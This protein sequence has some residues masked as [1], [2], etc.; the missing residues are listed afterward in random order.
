MESLRLPQGVKKV[1]VRKDRRN[2]REGRKLRNSSCRRTT[3]TPGTGR[4]GRT[5]GSGHGQVTF[6]GDG[7]R[8]IPGTSPSVSPLFSFST[9]RL[10]G[11]GHWGYSYTLGG[12]SPPR[13][14]VINPPISFPPKSHPIEDGGKKTP[15]QEEILEVQF[16]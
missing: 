10:T 3:G 13:R 7:P 2:P 5:R 14:V 11:S 12:V 8:L 16:E 1:S 4:F 6:G 15:P 9:I